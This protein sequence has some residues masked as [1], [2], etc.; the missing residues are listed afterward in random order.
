MSE[1][2]KVREVITLKGWNGSGWSYN[3]VY[4]DEIV[5]IVESDLKEIDWD[6][7]E[8]DAENPPEDGEDTKI[9]VDL[10]AADADIDEDEPLASHEKWAS[11]LYKE[12]H[13]KV[14]L[15]YEEKCDMARKFITDCEITDSREEFES[16]LEAMYLV[17]DIS[18]VKEAF[19]DDLENVFDFESE[20]DVGAF[21]DRHGIT[22]E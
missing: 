7:Y 3:Q 8:T 2:L 20:D 5:N 16:T 18:K 11:E 17:D 4:S 13:L 12:R 15:S 14:E 9:I 21:L 1:L 10:Y 6:W 22:W 19:I